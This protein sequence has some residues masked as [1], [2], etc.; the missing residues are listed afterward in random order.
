MAVQSSPGVVSN[1]V[2][3]TTV[4]PMNYTSYGALAGVFHW[5]PVGERVLVDSENVLVARFGKPSNF[6][7]ETF[8]TGANY[9]SYTNGLIVS[10][11]ANT[12]GA[13]PS[14]NVNSTNTSSN[15]YTCDT[16]NLRV[17]MY[18]TQSTNN[19]V[20]NAQL[21]PTIVAVNATAIVLSTKPTTNGVATLYF[22]NPETSYSAVAVDTS[23]T[24]AVVS[25]L[26]NQI[27]KNSN[28]YTYKDGLFD[29]D[30]LFVARYPGEDGN[31]LRISQ[32]D[33]ETSFNSNVVLSNTTVNTFIN[34]EIGE[35]FATI[36]FLGS[37]NTAAATIANSIAIGD[38]I[39]A[40]NDSIGQQYLLVTDKTITGN[41]TTSIIGINGNTDVNVATG[42]ISAPNW[43]NNQY[44]FRNGDI[45]V[46]NVADGNTA[47]GG[48]TDDSVYY[49]TDANTSGFKLTST[50]LGNVIALTPG[51]SEVGHSF[52][53]NTNTLK[54][55]TQDPFRLRSRYT[56]NTINR[57]WEFFNVVDVAPGQSDYVR[58][59][60][61]T[62][63]KDE[64]HIVVVDDGGKFTG[65]PGTILEV[66][67]NVSRAEDALNNDG[68]TNYYK[69]IINQSS[70]YIWWAAD[71]STAKSNTA[72]NITS[73]TS[74]APANMKLQFGSN[75][76]GEANVSI[77]VLANAYDLFA[78]PE[79]V[80][81][82]FVMQG[83]PL[84]GTTVVNGETISNFQLANYIIDN[85]V[86][87]RKDCIA[88][89]TPDKS[90]VLNNI[91][92]EAISL[93]NWRGAIR[94]S[95]YAV[96]DS[97]YKWQYDRYNNIYRWIP[98]NGDIA[99]LCARTDQTND[100]WWS[101][102]GFSRGQIKNVVKLAF[103]PRETE[104][105]VLYS[106]GINPV[107]SFPG[108]G[109][110]L[111][112]DKTLQSKSSAFD[113]IN[114]RRLFIVLRKAIS[115][116]AKQSLFEFNDSFTRA[117]FKN[118]VTPYLRTIQGRRGITDFIVI[119]D[120]TNNTPQIIDT[121]QFV[122]DIYIKPAR[123]IN[124]ISLNFVAVGSGVQFS[125]VVGK[126]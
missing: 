51:P 43:S 8:F 124:F 24:T 112:G 79:D 99:G 2:D 6:N 56:S 81:I 25:N 41:N 116:V 30:V 53:A 65:T 27:V 21:K 20:A 122:G 111:Y 88:T 33:N 14:I 49:V 98:L 12:T 102:G 75:G 50:P 23:N 92:R 7:A 58:F 19:A 86:N 55:S 46:Y 44:I 34:F 28:E 97:G 126:W 84:G 45:V 119:C 74:T 9:L 36:K 10:R 120:E 85:I 72:T 91:G 101:P 17:G 40:G 35:S 63:A 47:I 64:L 108:Q 26:V 18:V 1:E 83:K 62:A 82:S 48:L 90:K 11:A 80:D 22:A 77:S 32:C 42:F 114:V 89:I 76:F 61:N 110:I 57:F 13:T 104:R 121:N 113:R 125:E 94:D 100:A 105:N 70:Q 93:K 123:S 115:N 68:G 78:S 103:N 67:K 5:G 69:N 15:V 16:T 107:V 52:V 109:T 71:R 54:I 106:N 96:M 60:G 3:L 59:S 87:I 117:Q 4:V 66:Y 37:T 38:Y 31:S 118:L 29:L 39:L 73:S 95:S